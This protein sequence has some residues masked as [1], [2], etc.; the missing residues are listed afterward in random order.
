MKDPVSRSLVLPLAGFERI[1]DDG[2]RS[3]ATQALRTLDR[4]RQT[5]YLMTAG[6]EHLDQLRADEAV[7]PSN[8]GCCR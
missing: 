2:Q 1:A 8:E 3:R 6:R 7:S 4:V 5:K